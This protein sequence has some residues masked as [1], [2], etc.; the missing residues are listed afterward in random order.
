M[1]RNRIIK[2]RSFHILSCQAPGGVG[3]MD[4]GGA[5]T[6]YTPPP[7]CIYHTADILQV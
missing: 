4:A 7:G 5:Y 2:N 3:R 6:G 1:S